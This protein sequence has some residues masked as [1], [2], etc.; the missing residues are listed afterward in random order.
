[1]RQL[2]LGLLWSVAPALAQGVNAAFTGLV[3]DPAGQPV[4]AA[5]VELRSLSNGQRIAT[6]ST[7]AGLFRLSGL[8]TGA[9]ELSVEREG[10]KQYR[11]ESVELVAGQEVRRTLRLELGEVRETMVVSETLAEIERVSGNGVRGSSYTPREVANIPMLAGGQGRNYRAIAYQTAGVG[12]SQ[13]GH[14]PFTV[15]GNRPIG[16]INT[17]VDT[18]EYNDPA[19]GNLLGRGLTEQ[20]ISM[21]TVEAFEMQTSNFKAE[22]G[23]ASGAVV[24][25]VTKQGGNEWRG[26]A[27]YFLQNEKL[28]ARNPLLALRNP[29]RVNFPGVTLGGPLIQNKLF[30]FGG[31]EVNVRNAYR[32]SSTI[33]TLTAEDRARAVAAVRPLLVYYPEPNI[34]GTNLHS[35]AVP[36]PTTT[37]TGLFRFD[38]QATERHRLTARGN[39]VNA[40]GATRDRLGAGD[41]DTQNRSESLVLAADSILTPRLLN[42]FRGTYSTF[43]AGV[44]P[45]SPSLGDP[46]VNGQIGVLLVTGLPR[47]GTFIPLTETRTHNYTLANDVS[48][49]T[50]RHALKA[51]LI[52]RFIQYNSTSERNFNGT[53]VFP[54]IAQFLAGMPLT[55]SRAVGNSRIDQRNREVGFYVQDDWKLNP[56]LVL[57]LGVRYEYYAVPWDKHGR[58]TQ[59]YNRDFNNWAPRLGFAWDIGGRTTTVLR[60]GYGLFYSPLQ[61]DFVAQSRFG[62]PLVTTFTRFMPRFPNL[63]E[64]AVLGTDRYLLDRELVNP[65]VQNWNLTLERQL[66]TRNAVWSVAY[67][68]NRGLKLPRTVRPNGG[69]NLP[70]AQRPDPTQGVVTYLTAGVSSTYHALQTSLNYQLSQRFSTRATYTFS[71]VIDVASDTNL[72]PIDDRNYRLDRAVADFHQ[73]HLLTLYSVYDLPSAI[74]KPLFGGWRLST[75]LFARSGT[76]FSILANANNPFGTLNNRV[77]DIA[78]TID[79]SRRGS[80][81]LALSPGVRPGA[82]VPAP[83]SV[84]TLGRNT[85]TSPAFC[86][87]NVSLQK[88]LVLS[89]RWR[90]ELR[91]EAFNVLNRANYDPP[92]NNLANVAFGRILTAADARQMQL[93][94]RLAF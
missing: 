92:I 51:G 40:I 18:A 32:S 49:T 36:S 5:R 13:T 72:I 38:Y 4:A 21:E 48:Y 27:Y 30:F 74:W 59:A 60:G 93:L 17:M 79:R 37:P 52:G 24:N 88:S 85:E 54:S 77:N 91:G 8:A 34:A 3:L 20:P 35:A 23:R 50:G 86:D 25:L 46:A 87:L 83:G 22:F 39:W 78:G 9:Y 67:V 65:Y 6:E 43:F 11:L 2:L 16:A 61:M 90:L 19:S 80:Q 12:F 75:L 29:V 81:W 31:Y 28:N 57:N 53:I 44:Y 62:P 14:A 71:K 41:A 64:G 63:L 55:Y 94:L 15:N 58:L 73:P 33:T 66:F 1:M 26:T 45:S 56:Q 82:I 10:F 47:V 42:Q 76:P 84:G 69:E 89:E 7:D 70:P 68:G